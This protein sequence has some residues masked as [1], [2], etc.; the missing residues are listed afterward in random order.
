[1]RDTLIAP[2]HL[3]L[4]CKMTSG[5]IL[6][7]VSEISTDSRPSAAATSLTSSTGSTAS[8][9]TT[10]TTKLSSKKSS[11]RRRTSETLLA[12]ATAILKMLGV[13]TTSSSSSAAPEK[14]QSKVGG[15]VLAV[16]E[17]GSLLT[18]CSLL[19]RGP[20]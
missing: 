5:S 18:Y 6:H 16:C 7:V 20:K 11:R 13:S 3:H 9:T 15:V 1:M 8:S 10:T 12:T 4:I 19:L 14:G 17:G 2:A